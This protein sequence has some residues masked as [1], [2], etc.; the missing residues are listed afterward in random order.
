MKLLLSMLTTFAIIWTI[1]FIVG[2][3][4]GYGMR[5]SMIEAKG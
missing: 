3:G 1:S 4:F 2:N 5:N